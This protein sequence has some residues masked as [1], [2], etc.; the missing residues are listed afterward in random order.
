MNIWAADKT[1]DIKTML[2][3]LASELEHGQFCIDLSDQWGK[4]GVYISRKDAPDLR[5]YVYTTGQDAKCFGIDLEYPSQNNPNNLLQSHE[6]VTYAF[7]KDVLCTH[8]NLT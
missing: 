2:I 1:D 6:N 5:A 7:L 8:L 3:N 4:T